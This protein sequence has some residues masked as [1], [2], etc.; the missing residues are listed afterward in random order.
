MFKKIL[1][2]T[3]LLVMV[4]GCDKQDTSTTTDSGSSN[5]TIIDPY[6]YQKMLKTGMDVD[7]LKTEKG[8]Y[9]AQRSHD[10][11][12]NVPKLF[13]ER[14]LSHVRLRIKEDILSSAISNDTGK[15]LIQELDAIVDDCLEADIIP[16]IAY[17]ASDFKDNPDDDEVLEGVVKWW[18]SVATRYKEKSHKIAYDIVIETTGA[19][20]KRNDR[21]NLLYKK[22]AQAVH[23]I[24]EKRIVIVA[25]NKISNP[26]NLKD[27]V[28]PEPSDYIMAEWHF[29]AAGPNK[30]HPTKRWTTGTKEEQEMITNR[31]DTAVEWSKEHHVATWVGAWMANNYNKA[32]DKGATLDDGAPAGGEYSVDEQVQIATFISKTLQKSEVPYAVNSDTKFFNRETNEWYGSMKKVLDAMIAQYER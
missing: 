19:V 30:D 23:A 10:E 4:V 6:S 16:I 28:V 25:A 29:Y 2:L 3:A 24:D 15:T 8:R 5:S 32:G 12:V 21:L 17:Q 31:V 13:K 20:K 11:G 26:Y 9:W 22:V 27:L 1:I 18:E 7:W 14:G